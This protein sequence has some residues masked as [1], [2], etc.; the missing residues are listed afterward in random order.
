[1]RPSV[2]GLTVADTLFH[3]YVVAEISAQKRPDGVDC[4]LLGAATYHCRGRRDG[5]GA[6][7]TTAVTI[8]FEVADR[9]RHQV[10]LDVMHCDPDRSIVDRSNCH[11][12]GTSA[13]GNPSFVDALAEHGVRLSVWELPYLDP[14]RRTSPRPVT[15]AILSA[16]PDASPRRSRRHRRPTAGCVLWSTSRTRTRWP[17]GRA[18]TRSSSRR[19]R[20]VQRPTPPRTAGRR[21]TSTTLGGARAQPLPTAVQRG[22]QRRHPALH[23]RRPPVWGRSGWAGSQRYPGHGAA[24]PSPRSPACSRRSGADRPMR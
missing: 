14:S 21:P 24:T 17:G 5:W 7:E 3:L 16:R 10:P 23:G 20:G 19:S 11:F 12:I 9:W 22:G 4:A 8:R 2:L 18:R 1:M 6:A 13:V 15:R